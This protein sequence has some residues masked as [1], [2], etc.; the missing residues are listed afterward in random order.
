MKV[1]VFSTKAYDTRAAIAGL[2]SRQLGYLA[3]DVY[4][5]E[6]ELFFE[7]LS[8][9]IIQDDIFERLLTFP[10]VII[11]GHQAFFTAD[12]LHN[13]AETTLANITAIARG[14]SANTIDFLRES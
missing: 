11:T 2:K 14:Q 9:E 8:A 1:A 7:D 10:N 13:I 5:G 3:L 4:E 6:G 12:A